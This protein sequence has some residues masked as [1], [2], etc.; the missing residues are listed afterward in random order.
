[1]AKLIGS[2]VINEL[3]ENRLKNPKDIHIDHITLS[4]RITHVE[5]GVDVIS[6]MLKLG[7]IQRLCIAEAELSIAD[8][9]SL[10][11]GIR[12]ETKWI[13]VQSQHPQIKLD[14][15]KLRQND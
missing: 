15:E 8:S 12:D 9:A 1:M 13:R 6:Q 2:W 10:A 4:D 11:K 14:L 5:N 7:H 3:F